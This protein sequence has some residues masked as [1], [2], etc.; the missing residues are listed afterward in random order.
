MSQPTKAVE[1]VSAY[2]EIGFSACCFVGL[3]L[4]LLHYVYIMRQ[5]I[6]NPAIE[7]TEVY[8]LF[9]WLVITV[10]LVLI[11]LAKV[12]YPFLY[13]DTTLKTKKNQ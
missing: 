5:I 9:G 3:M 12:V 10:L 2:T 4:V 8:F 1:D 13:R 7:R 11:I 6:A